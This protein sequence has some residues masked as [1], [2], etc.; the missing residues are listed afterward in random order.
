MCHL[1][2]HEEDFHPRHQCQKLGHYFQ[3]LLEGC[4]SKINSEEL[5]LIARQGCL[6]GKNAVETV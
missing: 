2:R 4:F 5:H 1:P 3:H 6:T